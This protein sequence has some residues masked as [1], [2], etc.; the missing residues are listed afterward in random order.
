MILGTL[1][2]WGYQQRT[3]GDLLALMTSR[4]IDYVADVRINPW[5]HRTEWRR[6]ALERTLGARYQWIRELGNARYR[7]GGIQIVDLE[8]GLEKLG[9][10]LDNPS[11]ADGALAGRGRRVLLLCFERDPATCHRKVVADAARQRWGSSI[12]VEHLLG[13]GSPGCHGF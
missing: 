7:S 8:A 11:F 2:T 4:E 3:P 10:L 6:K 1:Y 5:S 13:P 9:Q 12:V